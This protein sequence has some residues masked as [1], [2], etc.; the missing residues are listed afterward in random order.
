MKNN[1]LIINNLFY[2]VR[3]AS[4]HCWVKIH[5][6]IK[7]AHW[8][9]G[10]PTKP[11]GDALAVKCVDVAGHFHSMAGRRIRCFVLQADVAVS[12]SRLRCL[13]AEHQEHLRRNELEL[14]IDLKPKCGMGNVAI[15]AGLTCQGREFRNLTLRKN[16][17][18]LLDSEVELL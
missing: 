4:L 14:F 11:L 8:A 3:E 16:V 13:H 2:E 1:E 7:L 10:A 15:P 17:L 18:P 6:Q 5:R 9:G 12:T